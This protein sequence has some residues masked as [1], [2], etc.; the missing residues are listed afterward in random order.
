M[1]KLA[2][3]YLGNHAGRHHRVSWPLLSTGRF[4]ILLIPCIW[5][6]TSR[7]AN[8]SAIPQVQSTG[9]PVMRA[10][11]IKRALAGRQLSTIPCSSAS[12][13]RV[14]DIKSDNYWLKLC[15]GASGSLCTGH[16]IA[17]DDFHG[18]VGNPSTLVL[19]DG[20][21]YGQ[22][23]TIVVKYLND[24]RAKL[25]LP[26]VRSSWMLSLCLFRVPQDQTETYPASPEL[27]TDL[28]CFPAGGTISRTSVRNATVP[29]CSSPARSSRCRRPTPRS[30]DA[31]SHPHGQ[32]ALPQQ[33]RAEG[34]L[35][36][37]SGDGD[38]RLWAASGARSASSG[39]WATASG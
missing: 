8:S 24:N 32:D 11:H 36:R 2:R 33:A 4:G 19:P 21:T 26:F 25:H 3:G 38:L 14:E 29:T 13:H 16:L 28:L 1:L 5:G 12:G 27:D 34:A 15:T 20:P 39:R 30:R 6:L 23:R 18:Y 22:M 37:G 9:G 10:K 35:P 31:R 7:Y 17:V